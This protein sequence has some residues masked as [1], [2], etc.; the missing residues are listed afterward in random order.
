[1]TQ[2]L[3]A[4]L[5]ALVA[6]TPLYDGQVEVRSLSPDRVDLAA[7]RLTPEPTRTEVA[8]NLLPEATPPAA[9]SP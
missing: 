2:R 7:Q 1:M 4:M 9:S 8:R 3:L 5:V 6:L